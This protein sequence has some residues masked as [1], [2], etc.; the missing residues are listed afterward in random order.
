MTKCPF[1][2]H[3]NSKEANFCGNCALDLT[4]KYNDTEI[5][6]RKTIRELLFSLKGKAKEEIGLN[7]QERDVHLI[8][9]RFPGTFFHLALKSIGKL[10]GKIQVDD[11]NKKEELE[12]EKL[13]VLR[14]ISKTLK[15]LKISK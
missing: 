9:E 13:K 15:D 11:N 4:R 8:A 6:G 3:E 2:D 1:C 7:L 10:A 12:L 14:E 5:E